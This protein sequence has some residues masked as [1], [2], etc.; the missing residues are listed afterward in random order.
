MSKKKQKTILP[1]GC[2]I[3]LGCQMALIP[4]DNTETYDALKQENKLLREQIQQ[5]I[6]EKTHANEMIRER[7]RTIIEL[8]RENE[9]LRNRITILEERLDTLEKKNKMML[10][11]IE[12]EHLHKLRNT[13]LIVIQDIN[14]YMKIR[15]ASSE[16]YKT[17]MERI[18]KSR[19]GECH[20]IDR[21]DDTEQIKLMKCVIAA[22]KI[23]ENMEIHEVLNKITQ[24]DTFTED[25]MT[26]LEGIKCEVIDAQELENISN[27]WDYNL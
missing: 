19:I 15:D 6:G 2:S 26:F 14:D 3:Q 20:Y 5:L 11:Y 27:W 24:C 7:D 9:E 12:K 18:R 10:Q 21:Q 22:K 8:K 4:A 23:R 25:F 16:P 17:Y 13:F 1:Q